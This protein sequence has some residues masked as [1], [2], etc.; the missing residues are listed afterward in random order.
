MS[1]YFYVKGAAFEQIIPLRVY[2]SLVTTASTTEFASSQAQLGVGT[3]IAT[4]GAEV[5]LNQSWSGFLAIN[6]LGGDQYA[7]SNSITIGG[8][9]TG[10]STAFADPYIEVDPNFANAS[11]YSIVVSQGIGNT[12]VSAAPEPSSL[13][14][15]AVALGCAGLLRRKKAGSMRIN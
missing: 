15:A 12:P 2:G 14:L 8:S 11:D 10:P 13:A 6:Y 9:A 1:Y 4:N 7:L 3:A 5:Q